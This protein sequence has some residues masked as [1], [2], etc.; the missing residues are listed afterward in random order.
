MGSVPSQQNDPVSLHKQAIQY[1]Q[2]GQFDQG[3]KLLKDALE[4]NPRSSDLHK[5]LGTAYWQKG[6]PEKAEQHYEKSLKLSPKNAQ[7]LNNYG[8][9]LISNDRIKKAEKLL[10]KAVEIDPNNPEIMNN[11]GMVYYQQKKLGLAGQFFEN[12]AKSAPNWAN[13]YYNLGLVFK[14]L[15]EFEKADIALRKALSLNNRHALAWLEL[16]HI[17]DIGKDLESTIKCYENSVR[18]Y[19]LNETAWTSLVGALEKAGELERADDLIQTAKNNFGKKHPV[20]ILAEAKIQRRNGNVNKAIELL[21]STLEIL[22]PNSYK[23][24]SI[25]YELGTLYDKAKKYELAF[26]QFKK[27][28]ELRKLH[29]G[30]SSFSYEDYPNKI[31]LMINISNNITSQPSQQSVDDYPDPVFLIG[32]PR[33]G[34]TLLEQ[35]L[36]SHKNTSLGEEIGAIDNL[37]LYCLHKYGQD[38]FKDI[39]NLSKDTLSELRANYFTSMKE[40]KLDVKDKVLI[41]K[42]PLNMTYTPLINLIFP[43]SKFILALRHPYDCVLSCFMQNFAFNESLIHFLDLENAANLYDGVFTAWRIFNKN[44]NLN[45]HHHFYEDLIQDFRPTIQSLLEF[46]ELEWNDS[47]LEY[48]KTAKTGQ[49]VYTPSYDQVT[50]KIYTHSS[51]RWKNYINQLEPTMVKLSPWIEYFDYNKP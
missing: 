30:L 39:H 2:K 38:Y 6:E 47:I 46:I 4:L 10:K 11:L 24:A 34:T 23:N 16:G 8:G 20:L 18:Y 14:D 26:E 17:M 19:P 50:E 37:Y 7:V 31:E 32:F 35:I 48:D 25:Y 36:K 9:F 3:I 33:S 15:E 51:G 21:I 22:N 44:H 29:P 43:N 13:P 1:L 42:M 45:V 41:D 12:A 49:G 28:N 5:D 27:A 40:Q